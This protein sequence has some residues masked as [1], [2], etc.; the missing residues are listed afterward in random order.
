MI[1]QLALIFLG[2]AMVAALFVIAPALFRREGD[3]RSARYWSA[4]VAGAAVLFSGLGMY[5]FLGRPDYALLS[6]KA[7]PNPENYYELV[8]YLTRA[9]RDRPNDIQGWAI[10]GGAYL[11]FGETDQAVG[12]YQRAMNIAQSQGANVP[13]DLAA[14]FAAARALQTGSVPRELEDVF[15]HVLTIDPANA[16]ARYHIGFAH[17]QRGENEAALALWEPLMG[18]PPSAAYWRANLP[19]QIEA[20]RGEATSAS[21]PESTGAL[22]AVTPDEGPDIG[23]MVAGLAARLTQEPNDIEGWTMLIRAYGVLGEIENARSA[24][25]NARAIFV[26]NEAAQNMLAEQARA[27]SLE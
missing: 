15:R 24:L 4:G 7:E 3:G 22:G 25:E 23:A 17:A 2:V 14:N 9:I 11:A 8:V 26:D 20:L 18:E 27:S 6:L 10:L 5:S 13:P 12:A 21:G 16:Q 1:L 19:F